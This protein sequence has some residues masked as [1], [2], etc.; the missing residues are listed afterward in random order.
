[1]V[2]TYKHICRFSCVGGCTHSLGNVFTSMSHFR[3]LDVRQSLTVL[4]PAY[5]IFEFGDDK[6]N[7]CYFCFY[8]LSARSIGICPHTWGLLTVGNAF[9][10]GGAG[11]TKN[12]SLGFGNKTIHQQ[13]QVYILLA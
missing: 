2:L 5:A 6:L 3:F 1:M 10:S 7:S 11:L 4:R 13:V 12:L 8:L 9:F